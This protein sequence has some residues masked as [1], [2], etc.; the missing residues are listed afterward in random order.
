MKKKILLS[1]ASV[2]F[3]V[4]IFTA[5]KKENGASSDNTTEA[6]VQSDD[7]ARVSGEVDAVAND[8]DVALESSASFTGRYSQSQVNL[9]CDAAVVY[10][11]F[12]NPR[13]ISI[14]YN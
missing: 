8:A 11:S 10:D 14:T 1:L 3:L 6:S 7:Q 9:I 5:C 4:A 12:S 13:T 2:L